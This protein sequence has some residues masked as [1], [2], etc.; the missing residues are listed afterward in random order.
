M[1]YI[2]NSPAN[3]GNYQIVD[4]I[5]SGFNGSATSF[6]LA[7]GSVGITPAKSGQ[8]L[9]NINGV[10]QQP[11]DA[12]TNG[13]KVSGSNI[14]FSSAPA[15]GDTFWA[16]Y[17]GQ[18]VDIG[19][20]SDD[21]VDTS[22]I[23][24]NAITADKIA[25]GAVVADIAT[26]GITTAKIADDA[27]TADKLAN[28]INSAIA[29]NTAKTGITSGQAS[30]I[31]ANTAKTGITSSQASAITANTAKTGITSSQASAITANTAKTGITSSQASAITANTAKTGITSSQASAITAALAKA[32][33][34]MTGDLILGDNV[35]LEVGS[36]SGGDLQIYHDGSHSR[37]KDAG[38]G[39]LYISGSD[40]VNIQDAAG[41]P[42]IN[43][44]ADGV[45]QLAYDGAYKLATSSA[46]V[47]VTGNII[48]SGTV[49]GVDVAA[50]STLATNAL[51]K[52]GG[53][54]TGDVIITKTS[55]DVSLTLYASEDNGA[56][57]PSLNLKGYATN[58]N[59]V[60]NFGD[61]AGYAG[62]IEYENSDNSMRLYTNASEKIRIDSAGKVGIGVT[63]GNRTL[64]IGTL[65][66]KTSTAVKYVMNIG[67]TT[68]AS[69]YA[70]LGVYFTGHANAT[71]RIWDFQP[72]E[73]GV[74]NDGIIQMN[75]NGG[76]FR[77]NR[78]VLFNTDTAAA[79]ILDDYEEG[80][81][82]A[83][84]TASTAPSSPPT[85][86]GTYIKIGRLV[87]IQV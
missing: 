67:Q 22:H 31:T 3:V 28:S 78:G 4:N 82:T 23:K 1:A 38:T 59:P 35:K 42:M 51:P 33:G 32:G 52:A 69:N 58:S 64:A 7:S 54:I 41:D 53:T 77:A 30:A 79:N 9:V 84:L 10:M 47:T 71:S 65:G 15:N 55:G 14:V 61:H 6:A 29:A 19:T 13:F 81:F 68:E 49:D 16:V 72:T 45:V 80:T 36:A 66:T 48:V 8:L 27:V 85:T 60:I 44:V 26:G 5:A 46:G 83:T 50:A 63:V 17:Q 21:T 34:T 40:Q 11:D 20:P 24:D 57:E 75:P 18:N 86:T 43:C 87:H 56:R 2:G 73:D 62:A 70:G 25:A 74:A 37:I 12:G 76:Y 39:N